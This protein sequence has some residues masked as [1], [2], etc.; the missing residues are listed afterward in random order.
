MAD[1]PFL[2]VDQPNFSQGLINFGGNKQQPQQLQ[3]QGQLLGQQLASLFQP[4]SSQPQTGSSSQPNVLAPAAYQ[5]M[6]NTASQYYGVSP[7]V[8]TQQ[9]KQESGFNTNS[10]SSAGARGIAQF[11]PGTA[12]RYG[13]DVTDPRS[14]ILGQ[15]HYMSD[16][17]KK[18]NGNTG[19]AL[20]GYNW[21]EGNV[22]K[23]LSGSRNM[24][25][26]PKETRDY[27]L[28]ITGRPIEAWVNQ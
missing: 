16:L 14:S 24:N 4:N 21:G 6:I 3:Q 19:L 26:I 1:N 27:V 10:T 12:A 13:V 8:L 28:K 2:V 18:F 23:W 22:Q 25:S 15:A 11:M 5:P 9:L 20:A 7:D 17:S